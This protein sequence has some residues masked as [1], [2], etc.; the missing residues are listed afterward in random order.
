MVAPIHTDELA[1]HVGRRVLL[2]GWL[3][4]FRDLGGVSFA[5]V[6]DGEGLA[7]VVVRSGETAAFL[8][9]LNL[10]SAIEIDGEVAA[11]PQ[12]PGGHAV[13]RCLRRRVAAC[14]R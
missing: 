14:H 2:R 13:D 6:R 7:Q 5:L 11:N 10:E 3:H 8:R 12:A 4:R 1:E 9:G